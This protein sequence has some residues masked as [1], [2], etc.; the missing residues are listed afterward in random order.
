MH[1]RQM[2]HYFEFASRWTVLLATLA[3]SLVSIFVVFPALPLGADLLDTRPG[4]GWQ[5]LLDAKEQYGV[6]GRRVYAWASPTVD[7]LFP[8]LYVTLFAGILYQFS[9]APAWR[10]LAWLPVFAG[11]WDLCANAQIT[12]ML[13][14]YPDITPGQMTGE[15]SKRFRGPHRRM[16]RLR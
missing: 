9:P 12:A 16:G 7:T 4:Y 8:L 14:M 1:G 6:S 10:A 11:L 15:R 3:A 5:E 2:K 13:L